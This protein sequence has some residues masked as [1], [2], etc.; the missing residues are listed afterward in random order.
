LEDLEMDDEEKENFKASL[1]SIK[2]PEKIEITKLSMI[3]EDNEQ[4]A[5]D[6]VFIIEDRIRVLL[7]FDINFFVEC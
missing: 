4:A 3:A 2:T 7:I 5:D 1:Y 6:I